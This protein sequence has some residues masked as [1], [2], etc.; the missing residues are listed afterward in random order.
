MSRAH[1]HRPRPARG[2]V[3][4]S[5]LLLLVIVT[6]I[7]I[8]MFKGFGI[9]ERIA[10]NLREKHRAL[11]AIFDEVHAWFRKT[12]RRSDPKGFWVGP[13]AGRAWKSEGLLLREAGHKGKLFG[14]WR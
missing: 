10:G 1:D 12:F 3:F 9:S 14:V 4:I 7:A 5:S 11:H 13:A 2:I 8:A 6:M